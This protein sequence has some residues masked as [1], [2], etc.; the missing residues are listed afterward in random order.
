MARIA[1]KWHDLA[2]IEPYG[3][4]STILAKAHPWQRVGPAAHRP[5]PAVCGFALPSLL[6]PC[7]RFQ[8]GYELLKVLAGS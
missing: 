1:A 2:R 6:A 4:K 3:A 7:R 8:L 5:P